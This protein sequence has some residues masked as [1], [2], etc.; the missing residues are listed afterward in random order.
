MFRKKGIKLKFAISLLVILT[1]FSTTVVN[2]YSSI[3]ALKGNL[4]ETYLENN[5]KYA[6]KITSSA[7][8]LFLSMQQNMNSLSDLIGQKDFTQEDL[9]KWQKTYR[10]YFNSVFT[11]DSNGVVQYMSPNSAD[12]K[13]K[14][15]TKIETDLMK[16]ALKNKKPF[17]SEPYLA[18]SGNLM[19]LISSPVFDGTGVYQGVVDGTVYLKSNNSLKEILYDHQFVDGSSVFVVD[20]SGKI[21]YHP[22]PNRI[23]ESIADHPVVQQLMQGKS[24]ASQIINRQETEYFSG[25]ASIEH[26]GWGVI[27]QTPTSIMEKPLRELTNKVIVQAL[28]LLLIILCNV[29]LIASN[30]SKPLDQ[31]ARISEE[32]IKYN[33]NAIPLQDKKIKSQIYEINQ[34]YHHVYNYLVLLNKQ[35][36]LDGLTNLG[37][38]RSFD[39]IIKEWFEHQISF[40]IILLDIDHFKKVN[41]TFGHLAGDDVIRHLSAL[42][43]RTSRKED[44]C[45][46]YGGEE[47]VILTNVKRE[48]DVL[49][50]AERLRISFAENANPTGQKITISL[51]IS[52]FR[53]DDY[54]PDD[55]IKRADAALYQS[56]SN[57][58]N[59]TTVYK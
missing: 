28:P 58:R 51:G 44:F 13:V 45:F 2:W 32:G 20:Q 1:A 34:L 55:I 6:K 11:T 38:R 8:G 35:V 33:R 39:L 22:D 24:G 49:R 48:E 5:N 14:P 4:T 10:N 53:I 15:G 25:Y 46:R 9:E 7:N 59:Q 19:L 3:I 23:N 18:Q 47:F 26:T 56:K 27:V 42:M 16:Q 54:Q 12:S 43:Q 57:G 29:W 41:D 31:L 36:Q 37:N 17:I 21:I 50:I 30:L 52:S 40:S